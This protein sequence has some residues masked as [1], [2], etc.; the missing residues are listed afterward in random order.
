MTKEELAAKLDGRQYGSEIT[1]AEAREAQEA[2]LL[3][4]YAAS[5]DLLEFE[6]ILADETSGPGEAL[7]SFA[8]E[9]LP[10][11]DL[12]EWQILK[13]Y[14]VAEEV[15]DK[16]TKAIKIISQRTPFSGFEWFI[17]AHYGTGIDVAPFRI[18][19]GKAPYC[20]GIV[21]QLP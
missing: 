21:L 18:F 16:R 8:G 15:R 9:L 11:P 17:D 19:D 1:Q 13:R 4:V 12:D 5:D 10:E 7:V 14:G 3:V 20:R 6:G 2:R